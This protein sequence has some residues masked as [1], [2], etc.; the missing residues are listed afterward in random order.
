MTCSIPRSLCAALLA[1]PVAFAVVPAGAQDAPPP[2]PPDPQPSPPPQPLPWYAQPAPYYPPAPYY[3]P[4]S[5]APPVQVVAP[6]HE[7]ATRGAWYGWQTLIAVAPFD[8]AMFA[9]LARFSTPAGL[10][11]FAVAF[12]ARN[13]V[14]AT[15][16]FA[17]GAVGRGFASVGLQAATTATGLALGFALGLAA[18]G[19][20][21]NL[22]NCDNDF[23]PAAGYGAIAGSMAGTVLD[24]VF[25]AHRS[26][27]SW[28]AA[29]N[30]PSWT[31]APFATQRTA[32][33]ALGGML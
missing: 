14:P 9:G 4:P 30:E 21:K 10:D 15:V 26:R 23:P 32:G 33:L 11:T 16:H 1:L 27:L 29:K 3:Q 2:P 20:C 28:T 24:V 6:D 5:Y 18:Q 7:R 22:A 31:M 17:H 19:P 12:T 8:I 25:F 13:L